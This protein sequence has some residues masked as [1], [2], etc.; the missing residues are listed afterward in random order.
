MLHD[1][2]L[3]KWLNSLDKL[4]D[5]RGNRRFKAICDTL[6]SSALRINELLALT[7]DDLDFVQSEISVSKTLMWKKANKKLGI[8]G[9]VI[10]KNTPKTD[11]GTRKVLVPKATLVQLRAFHEE[12]NLYFQKHGLP[13][14]DLIFPTIYGNYMC[15]R[16]E[17]VTLKNRLAALGLPEYGFHIFRHTHA[18]IML[19]AGAN[20]KELQVR[21]GHKSIN[22]T[23]DAYASL[24]PQKKAEAVNI[25]LDKIEELSA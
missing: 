19:N 18:S 3:A 8:K 6:L 14:S 23:M 17:R 21:M 13:Q 9:Q 1:E 11:S 4:P 10:C 20:W 16:N 24:A 7:I 22:T 2:D 15:D 25:F 12:M 5:T